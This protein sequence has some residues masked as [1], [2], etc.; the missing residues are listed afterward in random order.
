MSEDLLLL[1]L[2]YL[3]EKMEKTGEI[4]GVGVEGRNKIGRKIK[5]RRK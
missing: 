5:E 4:D 2:Q 1:I 3:G